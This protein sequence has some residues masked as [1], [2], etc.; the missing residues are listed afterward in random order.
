MRRSFASL[1]PNYE[2]KNRLRALQELVRM[3]SEAIK[4]VLSINQVP[5]R[6]ELNGLRR[7]KWNL[8][9]QKI[10]VYKHVY[11]INLYNLL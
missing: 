7:Q 11:F 9:S 5:G 10:K 8:A 3:Q 2:Q 6:N 1:L 4:Q